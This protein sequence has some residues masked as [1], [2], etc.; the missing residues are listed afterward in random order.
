MTQEESSSRPVRHAQ[1]VPLS[2]VQHLRSGF[3]WRSDRVRPAEFLD[4]WRPQQLLELERDQLAEAVVRRLAPRGRFL[5]ALPC[6]VSY[7]SKKLP[8]LR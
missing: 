5:G 2:V 7:E 6:G 4:W 3:N 1:V 8:R